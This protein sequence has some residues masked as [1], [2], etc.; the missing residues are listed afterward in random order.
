M[1]KLAEQAGTP[2]TEVVDAAVD[3]LER[4]VFFDEM[5]RRF[6]ELRAD[7]KAWA[8]IEEERAEWD[9][10]LMDGLRGDPYSTEDTPEPP[11]PLAG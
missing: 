8:E 9:A 10:T 4:Q 2:M 11:G 5:N 6:A 7:P 1:A 3:K